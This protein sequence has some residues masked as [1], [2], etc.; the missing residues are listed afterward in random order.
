MNS[1]KVRL[2]HI[3]VRENRCGKRDKPSRINKKPR[4]MVIISDF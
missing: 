3:P 2:S 4:L 1:A